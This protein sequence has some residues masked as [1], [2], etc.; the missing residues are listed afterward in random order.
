[1]AEVWVVDDVWGEDC[2]CGFVGL[3]FDPFMSLGEAGEHAG[4]HLLAVAV[5]DVGQDDAARCRAMT[6]VEGAGLGVEGV[7]SHVSLEWWSGRART[8]RVERFS[9]FRLR[10]HPP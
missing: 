8:W 5:V 3:L 1:V 10:D 2:G 7:V 4:L 6:G 9:F